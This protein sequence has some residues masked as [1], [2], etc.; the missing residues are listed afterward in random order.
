MPVVWTLAL[1]QD[2]AARLSAGRALGSG[3]ARGTWTEMIGGLLTAGA[4]VILPSIGR[5]VARTRPVEKPS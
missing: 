1:S 2:E 3:Q 5:P 4:G